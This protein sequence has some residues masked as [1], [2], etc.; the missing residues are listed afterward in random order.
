MAIARARALQ[1]KND[2][3]KSEEQARNVEK[4]F[5]LKVIKPGDAGEL[6]KFYRWNYF[7]HDLWLLFMFSQFSKVW[8]LHRTALLGISGR[9]NVL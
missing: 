5:Q 9:R 3:L 6:C 2:R 8:G 4:L 1:E 7:H